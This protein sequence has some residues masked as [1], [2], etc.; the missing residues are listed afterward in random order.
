M[1]GRTI[2]LIVVSAMLA[3]TLAAQTHKDYRFNVGPKSGVSVNNPY[4]SISVKPSAGNVVVINAVLA[5]DRVEVDT[6]LIG[7]RVEIQSH[8][9]PGA[10]AQ[11]GRVDYEMQVPVDA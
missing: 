3:G 6:N 9:L 7:N 5:S 8:L 4:G 10:D 11:S 1:S 2:E